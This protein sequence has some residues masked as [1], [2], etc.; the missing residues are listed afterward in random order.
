MFLLFAPELH[1]TVSAHDSDIYAS[2]EP[3]GHDFPTPGRH[4]NAGT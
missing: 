3:V 1:T 4:E 2:V